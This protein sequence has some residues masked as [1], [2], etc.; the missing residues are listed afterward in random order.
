MLAI[1]GAITGLLGPITSLTKQ[2]KELQ[3]KRL[4]VEGDKNLKEIDAQIEEVNSKKAV[5]IAQA[6]SRVGM[7]FQGVGQLYL[8]LPLGAIV[9]KYAYDKVV[10]PFHGCSGEIPR[11]LIQH[12]KQ[13]RTDSIDPHVWWAIGAMIAFYYVTKVVRK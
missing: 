1:L 2:Y 11:E 4:E 6:G 13:F 9:W 3:M 12:C 5:L 7:F 8:T 10:G